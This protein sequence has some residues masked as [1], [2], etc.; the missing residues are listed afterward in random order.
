MSWMPASTVIAYL[1]CAAMLL[2]A[3]ALRARCG[4]WSN[5][6]VVFALFWGM[7]TLM[8]V[9]FVPEIEPSAYAIGYIAAAVFAFGLPAF[10]FN[11]SGPLAASAAR[12]QSNTSS[13]FLSGNEA[14]LLLFAGQALVLGCM[15][16]NVAYQGFSVVEFILDPFSLGCKYLPY[17]YNGHLKQVHIAQ[18]GV[19]LNYISASFAG[20]IIANRNGYLTPSFAIFL[21]LVPSLYSAS[22]YGDKGTILLTIA[23]LYGSVVVGRIRNGSTAL[24]TFRT[25]AAIIPILLIVASVV[26]I[27]MMNRGGG[28]CV[29]QE[30]KDNQEELM[31]LSEG[32]IESDTGETA[33]G[34]AGD[35]AV[36]TASEPAT[37]RLKFSLR[38]YAFG[39]IFA[40]SSWFDHRLIGGDMLPEHTEPKPEFHPQWNLHGEPALYRNP[41]DLTYG[42]WTFMAIAQ[43]ID[44]NYAALVPEGYYDEY[45]LKEGV[46]QTNVYTFF[47]GLINDFGI[48]GSMIS[49]IFIG[50]TLNYAYRRQLLLKASAAS[51][52]LYIHYAG[53]LYTSAFISLLIWSSVIASAIGTFVMLAVIDYIDRN[54]GSFWDVLSL[55]HKRTGR[56]G[57]AK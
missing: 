5:P 52:A 55:R 3:C 1:L 35:A 38:S 57:E 41:K 7:M 51:Q 4:S 26:G 47:R 9:F 30:P 29:S 50:A 2:F 6:S 28:S 8:P 22:A 18:I 34:N 31:A 23:F 54:G 43:Y 37:S 27:A 20:L 10:F 48:A 44:P 42:F 14:M 40:F 45:F 21:S 11:W 15:A 32:A 33:G 13:T 12:R 39:H 16:A 25:I 17:R 56:A 53:Y 36:P 19:I 46:I 24:I 49:L